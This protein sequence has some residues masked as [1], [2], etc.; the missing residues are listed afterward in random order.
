[1]KTDIKDQKSETNDQK[2][3]S[4]KLEAAP[5]PGS[6][7]WK[8]YKS[9]VCE[10]ALSIKKKMDKLASQLGEVKETLQVIFAEDPAQY[11]C[12]LG[13]VKLD[14]TNSY[15]IDEGN[16]GKVK[17]LLAKN[18]LVIDDYILTRTSFGITAKLRSLIQEETEVARSIDQLVTI[19]QSESISIKTA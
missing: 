19:K 5:K 6:K 15:S 7:E 4:R 9:E 16:L 12:E 17:K 11:F 10:H 8:K 13:T 18:K 1:M 2:S 14:K 3:G